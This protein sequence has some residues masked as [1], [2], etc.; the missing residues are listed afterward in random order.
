MVQSSCFFA[1]IFSEDGAGKQP[2]PMLVGPQ[3]VSASAARRR[4]LNRNGAASATHP[5]YRQY[6]FEN[7]NGSRLWA[8]ECGMICYFRPE[9][10]KRYAFI[11]TRYGEGMGLKAMPYR[12]RQKDTLAQRDYPAGRAG[13]GSGVSL[14]IFKMRE[15]HGIHVWPAWEGFSM[16]PKFSKKTQVASHW[17]EKT[18]VRA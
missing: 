17:A 15:A 18:I 13:H 11:F 3:P 9:A 2:R 8:D 16:R 14:Q 10:N 12:G 5:Q 6:A 7:T 1:E 4:I